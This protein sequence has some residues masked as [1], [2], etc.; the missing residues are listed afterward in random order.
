MGKQTFKS[1]GIPTLSIVECGGDLIISGSPRSEIFLHAEQSDLEAS[2]EDNTIMATCQSDLRVEAPYGTSIQIQKV[3]G[4]LVIKRVQGAIALGVVEGDLA[5]SRVGAATIDQVGG[6]LAG[7]VVDGDLVVKEVQGDMSVRNVNGQ[8][9]IDLVGRDL[10]ARELQGDAFAEEVQGDVRLRTAFL[11]GHEYRFKALGDIVARVPLDTDADLTLR[12]GRNNIRVKAALLDRVE[13]DG[14]VTGR[15]GSGG[16]KVNL[17]A[18]K[19]L[20]LVARGSSWGQ[21]GADIGAL[22]ADIGVEFGTEFA[23]LAEEIAAQVQEHMEG[24]SAQLEEKLAHLEV[25]VAVIDQRA[26]KAAERAAE[27]ARR[28]IER[29]AEHLRRK[30]ER[31]AEKARR[32]ADKARWKANRYSRRAAPTPE[33]AGEPVSDKERLVILNMVA[34]GKI[35]IEEAE[36]LLEAL[37]T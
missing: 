25:D 13:T 6:D 20:V 28:Q 35:S 12:S 15:L 4:D 29:A 24:V 22:G 16:A 17:D 14:Q 32:R 26:A 30:A 19:D 9:M 21:V 27:Q 36:S 8:V 10:G 33:P 1:E 23:S 11:P 34:E 31:E 2:Q 18:E 7:R 3:R 37:N 5:L